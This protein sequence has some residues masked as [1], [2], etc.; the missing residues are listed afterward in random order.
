MPSSDLKPPAI[1]IVGP[2]GVG[3]SEIAIRLAQEL[4]GEIISADSR[5]AYRWMD[6]GTDKPD[7]RDR[8][9]VRHHLI[10]VVDPDE[11][12]TLAD[13]QPAAVSAASDIYS[14]GSLPFVVGGTGQYVRALTE[15]WRIPSQESDPTL[16]RD[17]EQI[18]SGEG[19][20][21]LHDRLKS[22]DPKAA[23][24]IDRR[25]PR[26][27]IR[28]LEVIYRTGAPFSSQ[29]TS[30]GPLLQFLMIGLSRPRDELYRRID[31]RIER[32]VRSGLVTEV[33]GLLARGYSADLPSFSA[34]GYREMAAFLRGEATLEHAVTVMKRRSRQLVR[35][36][37]N[38]FKKGD[39]EIHWLE[40]DEDSV[41]RAIETVHE[42]LSKGGLVGQNGRD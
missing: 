4:G 7:L 34:I 29:R 42:F 27:V 31:V 40:V 32:M 23:V 35:R 10:D 11:S 22:L 17:L 14:R 3:K 41:S 25:N 36:Q 15:G 24:E 5:L 1:F 33:E 20:D 26:R 38:W 2:T 13:F 6:I 8:A 19:L 21:A 28:A 30:A 18:A 12:W 9:G 16:R 39:P 37:A